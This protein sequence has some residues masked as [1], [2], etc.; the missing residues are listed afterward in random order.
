HTVSKNKADADALLSL[1]FGGRGEDL[2]KSFEVKMVGWETVDK[3]RTA[4]LELVPKDAE[5]RTKFSKVDMWVDPVRNVPLQQQ[6]F[7]EPSG[8]YKLAH[9]S[10]IKVNSHVSD[11][12]FRLKTSSKTKVVHLQ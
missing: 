9:Y 4:R 7:F 11:D 10:N 12:D 3:V 8:D 2:L 6:W 1:G 5:L